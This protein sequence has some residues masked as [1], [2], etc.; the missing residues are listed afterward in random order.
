MNTELKILLQKGSIFMLPIIAWACIVI[1]V[2]PF[3]YFNLS[4]TISK[5]SKENAKHE[6]ARFEK[7]LFD[8]NEEN[9]AINL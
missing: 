7:S 2:D 8:I 5:H 9:V 6:G 3:N 4:N 1:I